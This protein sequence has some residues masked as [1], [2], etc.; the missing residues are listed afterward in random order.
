MLC[1][2]VT[3]HGIMLIIRGVPT[4]LATEPSIALTI[5]THIRWDNTVLHIIGWD[6]WENSEQ[7]TMF[8][9]VPAT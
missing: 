1:L 7:V 3:E 2:P 5:H 8:G 9:W 4:P 6:T